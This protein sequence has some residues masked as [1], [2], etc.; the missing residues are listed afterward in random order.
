MKASTIVLVI[1]APILA[2]VLGTHAGK[3][4]AASSS[5]IRWSDNIAVL[6][7]FCRHV[8]ADVTETECLIALGA[9]I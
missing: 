1:A 6:H 5:D 9:M 8:Q 7:Y 3:T 4:L 2:A